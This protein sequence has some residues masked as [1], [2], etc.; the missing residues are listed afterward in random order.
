MRN[1]LLGLVVPVLYGIHLQ[2]ATFRVKMSLTIVRAPGAK[3]T[4]FRV[5]GVS[6]L[7]YH[8]CSRRHDF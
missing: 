6:A 7:L 3:E 5:N 4:R 2:R 8:S 1:C